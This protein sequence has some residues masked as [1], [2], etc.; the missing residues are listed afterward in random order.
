ATIASIESYNEVRLN[1][2]KFA[3]FTRT[4]APTFFAISDKPIN[5][6]DTSNRHR[7]PFQTVG[8]AFAN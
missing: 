1:E 6:D 5:V 3:R 7:Q 8:T 2:S 4:R